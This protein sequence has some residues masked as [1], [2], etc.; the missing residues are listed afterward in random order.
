MHFHYNSSAKLINYALKGPLCG[1][2]LSLFKIQLVVW[3]TKDVV[4]GKG[5]VPSPCF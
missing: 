1:V 5:K 4:A 3:G 2:V